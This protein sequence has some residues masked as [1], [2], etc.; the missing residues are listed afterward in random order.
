MKLA[1][2]LDLM[3][4]PGTRL[5]QVHESGNGRVYYVIPGGPVTDEIAEKIKAHPLV[6]AGKDGLFPGHSQTWRIK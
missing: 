6:V 3:R 4:I 2:A 1:K 5:V